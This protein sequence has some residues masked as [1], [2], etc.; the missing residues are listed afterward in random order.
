MPDFRKP[1][2][3]ALE[4]GEMKQKRYVRQEGLKPEDIPSPEVAAQMKRDMEYQRMDEMERRAAAS[5]PT[6]RRTMG[7]AFAKGG[8]VGSAS[9]RADGIAQRGKTKGKLI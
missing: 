6:T 5:A 9:R 2:P 8:K 4:T 7:Q 3:R 1:Q